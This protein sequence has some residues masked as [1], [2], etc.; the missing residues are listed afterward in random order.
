MISASITPEER[1]TGQATYN[2][3]TIIEKSPDMFGVS[4]FVKDGKGD[5]FHSYSTYHRGTELLMG[6]HNWLDLVPKGRNEAEG[7]MA[8]MRL[9]DEY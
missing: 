4:V 8:W 3:G 1:A 5:I 6:A 9:H 7:T 2:Y